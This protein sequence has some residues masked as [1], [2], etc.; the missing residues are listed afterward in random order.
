M[1]H[2]LGLD[3]MIVANACLEW[4]RRRLR[5]VGSAGSVD[6][7]KFERLSLS[8][9]M[10][11]LRG[12]GRIRINI[13]QRSSNTIKCNPDLLPKFLWLGTLSGYG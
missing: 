10:F 8:H 6:D 7:G 9:T 11:M 13:K 1:R 3:N 12:E 5:R 4:V 2:R